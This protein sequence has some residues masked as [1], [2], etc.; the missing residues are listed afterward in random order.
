MPDWQTR[1]CADAAMEAAA[2]ARGCPVEQLWTELG[3]RPRS[4]REAAALYRR[5]GVR[6]LAEAAGKL[7]APIDRRQARRG[8]VV[9]VKGSLGICRGELVE[10]LGEN[11][12]PVMVP[13]RHVERAWRVGGRDAPSAKGQI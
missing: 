1:T 8:D 5:L 10:C 7:G 9:M 11:D 6:T 3:G 4:W 2:A 12:E 13:L